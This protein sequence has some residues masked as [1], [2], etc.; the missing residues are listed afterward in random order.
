MNRT[1]M[2]GMALAA[3][4]LAGSARAQAQQ[5]TQ[6]PEG[7]RKE[8]EQQST[9]QISQLRAVTI[10][11]QNVDPKSHTVTFQAHV[12]PEANFKSGQGTPIRIDDL[13]KGDQVRAAFDPKTGEVVAV[14]VLRAGKGGTTGGAGGGAGGGGAGGAA[15]GG[16]GAGGS[17]GGSTPPSK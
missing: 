10:T 11:V 6:Q 5:Q 1:L 3:L 2:A 14:Q 12:K 4:G 9:Q 15:G 8:M 13:K 7:I 17:S 16:T